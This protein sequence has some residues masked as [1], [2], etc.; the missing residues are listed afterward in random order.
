[1][2]SFVQTY[3][4]MFRGT[5]GLRGQLMEVLT[6]EDLAFRPGGDT[7]TLGALCQEMGEV[8]QSYI[9]SFKTFKQ[10]W[11]YRHNDDVE[12]SVEKL[13]A[14]FKALDGELNRV[15]A[16]LTEAQLDQPI[17]RNRLSVPARSQPHIYE[18]ALFIFYGKA[19][20]YLR[21]LGKPLPGVWPEWI[22]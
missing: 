22:G 1:M 4:E 7:L 9:N 5:Q 15:I 11:S 21:A 14:W 17:E 16:S 3:F 12:R 19:S 18:D 6:D 13:R 10:D 2:N 20:I 8:E